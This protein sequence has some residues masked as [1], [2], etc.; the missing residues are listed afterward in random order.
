MYK[1]VQQLMLMQY[2]LAVPNACVQMNQQQMYKT[3]CAL[4]Y[5]AFQYSI[6]C[7]YSSMLST[8]APTLKKGLL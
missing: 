8:R 2:K 5:Y 1:T 7:M 6:H 3:V 4:L